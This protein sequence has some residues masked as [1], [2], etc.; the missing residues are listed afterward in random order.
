MSSDVLDCLFAQRKC[1]FLLADMGQ[2]KSLSSDDT[3]NSEWQEKSL[4]NIRGWEKKN[5]RQRAGMQKNR[6]KG[7]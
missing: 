1:V 2:S 7:K 3:E 5:L 4:S 6:Q